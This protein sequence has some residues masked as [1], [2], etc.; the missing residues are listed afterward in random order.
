MLFEGVGEPP[1]GVSVTE[2]LLFEVAVVGELLESVE[3]AAAAEADRVGDFAGGKDGVGTGVEDVEDLPVGNGW[4]ST[5][6]SHARLHKY[7]SVKQF[8]P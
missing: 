7:R 5:R 4:L 2:F 8:P 6:R 1:D 3:G